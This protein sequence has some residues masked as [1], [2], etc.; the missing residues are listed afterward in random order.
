MH[1]NRAGAVNVTYS[2]KATGHTVT[3][4]ERPS[5]ELNFFLIST[6]KNS[7]G[8]RSDRFFNAGCKNFSGQ[9]GECVFIS[10]ALL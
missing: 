8:E 10:I 2:Q 9:R 7:H 1:R 4:T 3:D 5:F 6:V